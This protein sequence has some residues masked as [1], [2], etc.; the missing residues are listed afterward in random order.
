MGTAKQHTTHQVSKTPLPNQ[1]AHAGFFFSGA[2]MK[3]RPILFS[4]PMVRALLAG[5]KTQTRRVFKAKNGGVWPN[6]NDLPGMQQIMRSCPYG[7]P[8]DRLWVRENFDFLPAGGPDEPQACEIVYWVTGSREPRECPHD[9]NP[10]IYGR[11]KIRPSIHMPRW[12]SRITLEITSVRVERLQDIS[13]KDCWAEG[14]EEVMHDFDDASQC[15][16]A[17]RLGCCIEDAKPLYAQLWEHIN[18]QGSWDANPWVW[19]IEFKRIT[20]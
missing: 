15:D 20:P 11:E 1:P 2:K 10:M 18:G 19:V 17:K 12:A 16:M 4:A 7:Q 13:E 8:G 9:Y 14:I 6:K 3:E 5:T